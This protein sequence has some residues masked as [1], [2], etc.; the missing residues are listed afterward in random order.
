MARCLAAFFTWLGFYL[1]QDLGRIA[2]ENA[3]WK[4]FFI[5][6]CYHFLSLFIAA[7][8]VSCSED[9]STDSKMKV[10]QEKL[11]ATANQQVGLPAITNFQEKRTL[12]EIYE[13]RDQEK[14]IC[15]AYIVAEMTGKLVFIGKCYG[16]GIPYSTQYSNPEKRMHYGNHAY[17][18][19]QAEPNGLY[20]PSSASGTWLLMLDAKGIPHPIYVEPNV[21][22]SP[23]E[24]S[25]L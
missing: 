6:T 7:M 2:W 20:M 1:P 17:I 3:S 10:A 11:T 24:L 14:L 13:L 4:L 19:P 18:L 12:K 5:N 16:Y 25:T 22:V 9:N 21:I 23:F 15:Y 8:I